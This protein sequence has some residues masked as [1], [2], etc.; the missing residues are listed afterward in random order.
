MMG[1]LLFDLAHP[2]RQYFFAKSG[3]DFGSAAFSF[4]FPKK[5]IN[6]SAPIPI[7]TG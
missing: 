4:L 3:Q 2:V 7:S 1:R 5:M 6:S